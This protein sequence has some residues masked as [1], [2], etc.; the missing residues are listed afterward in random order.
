MDIHQTI[1]TRRSPTEFT[2]RVPTRDEI[3]RLLDTAVM[4]PNHKMTQPWHFYVFGDEAKKAYAELR[5]ELKSQKGEDPEVRRRV[6]EK[7]SA[8]I[9]KVPALL[10]VAMRQ[11]RRPRRH[12]APLGRRSPL[13]SHPDQQR[14]P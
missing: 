10:A 2:A 13:V 3:E 1:R 11:A 5:G 6:M 9:M 4:A 7:V 14:H 8:G 12:Q